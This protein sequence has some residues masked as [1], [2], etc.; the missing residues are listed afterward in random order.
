[1]MN[2]PYTP[3]FTYLYLNDLNKEVIENNDQKAQAKVCQIK[4]I[5]VT[6]RFKDTWLNNWK[7]RVNK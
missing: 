7:E 1:M 2:N 3:E 5:T 6:N 4:N